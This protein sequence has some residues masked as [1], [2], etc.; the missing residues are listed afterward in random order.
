MHR[1]HRM[2]GS[3]GKGA[4]TWAA[5]M[6]ADR[7]RLGV[8]IAGAAAALAVGVL[9]GRASHRIVTERTQGRPR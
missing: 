2:H 6:E 9:L 8:V 5:V 7:A 1:Y 4:K 3:F